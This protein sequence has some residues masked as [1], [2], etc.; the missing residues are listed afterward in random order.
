MADGVSHIFNCSESE[1]VSS[2]IACF[3]K[4][5]C[6]F[7]RKGDTV[8][9]TGKGFKGFSKPKEAL[10]AGNSG[11]TTRLIS[12]ILCA[13]NFETEITGDESLSR[14]PMTRIIWPLRLM[15]ARISGNENGMLPLYIE[16]PFSLKPVNYRLQIPSAQVKSALLLCGLHIEEE[17]AILEPVATRNHTE[18]LLGLRVE[19]SALGKKIY[20]S[21]KNYPQPF[22]ITVPSD[23]SSAAFFIVLTLLSKRSEIVMENLSV[24]ETRTGI[25][26]IL[27][28]MGAKIEIEDLRKEKGEDIGNVRVLSSKLKNVPIPESLVPNIID[29]IPVLAV[30]GIFAKGNFKITN[31][32]E[33]RIK[34]SDRIKSLCQNFRRAGLDVKEF[35]D[36]FELIGEAS[37]RN[38][39]FESFGDHRIA[40]AFGVLSMLTKEGGAVNDFECAAISNP[41]FMKQVKSLAQSSKI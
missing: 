20:V 2:S 19:P 23:I 22:D 4:L 24:N 13:Q 10:Y 3:E 30:A 7:V 36:G 16:P 39:M 21:K 1:D 38:T 41:D 11:T 33:L 17:T 34:E 9:V 14:R 37:E 6:T 8:T 28:E 27:R 25:I 18:K 40:M 15:G 12:G 29:E 35:D 32:K 31:A 5:G 26:E